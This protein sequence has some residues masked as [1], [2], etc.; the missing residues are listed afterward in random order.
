MATF[1]NARFLTQPLTGVQR[2]SLEIS[3]QLILIRDDLIFLVHCKNE[4]IDQ[5]LLNLFNIQEIKGGKGHYWEQVTLPLY[6]RK[7]GNPLLLNLSN[8][9]PIFYGNKISTLHDIIF[10]KYPQSFSR[11]FIL[12]YKL[13]FPL[14]LKTS[15]SIITVSEFSKKDISNFY[16]YDSSKVEVIYNATSSFFSKE[17]NANIEKNNN[18]EYCLAVSSPNYHKNF[19]ALIEVYNKIDTNVELKIV[20]S[21][22]AVF[23]HMNYKENNSNIKFLGRASDDELVELYRNAKYFI[24]P[25]L[26]EGFGI[27]PLEAQACGCPVIS[28]NAASLPEVLNNSAIYFDPLNP[29]EMKEV[30][31]NS[32]DDEL[33]RNELIKRGFS[34]VKKYSWSFSAKKLNKLLI[35][36]DKS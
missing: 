34:N 21:A 2:F 23:S 25:S 11:Q 28:S 15:K 22:S 29:A 18:N 33:L 9:A 32:L 5:S 1:I 19:S 31:Q 26:Y 14:I 35:K 13:L 36:L 16:K 24:F 7:N 8:T 27:P 30:I 6:L 4:I 10:I 20:G 17:T 3:K 12:F